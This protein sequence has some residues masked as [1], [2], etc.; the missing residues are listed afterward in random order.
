MA[1]V[2]NRDSRIIIQGITGKVGRI[3]T[4]RMLRFHTPLVGGVAPGK[5]GSRYD[6]VPVFDLVEEAVREVGADT[7]LIIVPSRFIKSA[8]Y[9]AV[10]A[11]IRNVVIYAEGIPVKDSLCFLEY[12]RIKGVNVFGPNSAGVFSPGEANIS[13]LQDDICGIRKGP[14][15]IVSKSGTLTYEIVDIIARSGLGVS[16]VACLGGDPVVGMDYDKTL[17]L[18]LEDH[19]TQ[20]IVMLGEIGGYLEIDAAQTVRQSKK[21]IIA[22]IAGQKV[23]PGKKMGHAGAIITKGDDSA[24]A[25]NQVL[26]DNG[27]ITVSQIGHI[28]PELLRC[29]A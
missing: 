5:G 7:T 19:E 10:D 12:A 1:I 20:A 6:N 13:D 24:E 8:V 29:L 28:G 16:T 23:P 11:G 27:A 22:Y 2:V 18:F 9:E 15:G 17:Q 3:F 25:K 26:S 4:D 14:V 21:P